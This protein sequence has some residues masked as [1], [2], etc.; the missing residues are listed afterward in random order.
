MLDQVPSGVLAL[1]GAA[2]HL[3]R[4]L[5]REA[6]D[7]RAAEGVLALRELVFV[8]IM[9]V[10]LF[11]SFAV[12]VYY[13]VGSGPDRTCVCLCLMYVMMFVMCC[14]IVYGFGGSGP[15]GTRQR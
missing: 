4:R 13:V 7:L 11:V 5:P 2:V 15:D 14:F 8:L 3:P 12:R 6:D 1:E 10:C 9:F